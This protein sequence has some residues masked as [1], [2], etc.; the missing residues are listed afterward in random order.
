MRQCAPLLGTLDRIGAQ[1][2]LTMTENISYY[3][4][5]LTL[6][7]QSATQRQW[8][9][10]F[11]H[12][13]RTATQNC[14]WKGDLAAPLC[15]EH[16]WLEAEAYMCTEQKYTEH[17]PCACNSCSNTS[18]ATNEDTLHKQAA[19]KQNTLCHVAKTRPKISCQSSTI[20]T[21]RR[22][23]VTNAMKAGTPRTT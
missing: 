13:N 21:R 10:D 8:L 14:M 6:R 17:S 11:G 22:Q 16:I 9:Q 1:N 15:T 5:E 3:A 19:T 2:P 18:H 12:S 23:Q 4:K 7:S 20:H